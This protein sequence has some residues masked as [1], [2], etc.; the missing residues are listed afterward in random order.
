M[1]QN[2][3]NFDRKS[4]TFKIERSDYFSL[5]SNSSR[6]LINNDCYTTSIPDRK[7]GAIARALR[8]IPVSK[9]WFYFRR[10]GVICLCP[11]PRTWTKYMPAGAPANE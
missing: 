9:R 2:W 10:I 1:I 6:T 5:V 7:K 8:S 11:A 4:K 3:R